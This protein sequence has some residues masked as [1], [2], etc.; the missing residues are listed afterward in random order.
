MK[1]RNIDS[2]ISNNNKLINFINQFFFAW[3]F[4]PQSL[5]LL[6]SRA[7]VTTTPNFSEFKMT[8][9][10]SMPENQL[11]TLGVLLVTLDVRIAVKYFYMSHWQ[12]RLPIII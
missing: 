11:G 6:S 10:I 4:V 12:L 8:G 5:R 7:L 3:R 1:Q 2:C 9:L